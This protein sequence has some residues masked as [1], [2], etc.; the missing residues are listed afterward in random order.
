[1]SPT[2]IFS[3]K[4]SNLGPDH[5][6]RPKCVRLSEASWSAGHDEQVCFFG[7]DRFYSLYSPWAGL[8][9]K[10][11]MTLKLKTHSGELSSV[12]LF[13]RRCF[14]RKGTGTI[15]RSD[16]QMLFEVSRQFPVNET[17][18]SG[19][20]TS[21]RAWKTR[22]SR[23]CWTRATWRGTVPSLTWTSVQSRISCEKQPVFDT[24]GWHVCPS[25]RQQRCSCFA[26]G[27]PMQ[28][29]D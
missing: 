11:I 19:F 5:S 3:C 24:W 12:M 8:W 22:R 27:S 4:S 9:W 14:D 2:C 21:V 7:Q 10:E 16:A 18:F 13:L 20:R 23:G 25:I 28:F 17:D 6:N 29:Q 1:M 15:P 26:K